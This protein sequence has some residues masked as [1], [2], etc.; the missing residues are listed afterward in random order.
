M[1]VATTITV[2]LGGLLTGAVVP[3]LCS[4][5]HNQKAKLD[6]ETKDILEKHGKTLEHIKA[7]QD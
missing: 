7:Q 3:Y 2:A 5:F 1:E 4:L 6:K